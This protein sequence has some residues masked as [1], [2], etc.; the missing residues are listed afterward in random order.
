[1]EKGH[2][3]KY[4]MM[5]YDTKDL[6]IRDDIMSKAKELAELISGSEEVQQFQKAEE[7]IRNHER[8]QSLIATIKKKQ[9]E[10]VAFESF[11]NQE[12][13]AKIEKEIEALQDEIDA[14]PLV[15]EFQQS[16]S[17]INY[18]LQLVIS[19]IHDTV[20]EK[21][22]VEAGTEAPPSSCG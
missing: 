2:I 7:K 4:G 20:S 6:V 12:M 13:V 22:N 11:Q 5:S 3:N 9:K 21:V 17:D 19:V 1:M 14:I 8:V 16:Q 15:N 18:L 10:I